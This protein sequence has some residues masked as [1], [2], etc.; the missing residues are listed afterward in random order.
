[1][2]K[3]RAGKLEFSDLSGACRYA[4]SIGVK[5][6]YYRDGEWAILKNLYY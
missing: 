3:F 5:V 4:D 2:K 6:E 1:M